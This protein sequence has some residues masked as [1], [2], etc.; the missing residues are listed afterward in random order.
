MALGIFAALA[1]GCSRSEPDTFRSVASGTPDTAAQDQGKPRQINMVYPSA[2]ALFPPE[3]AA[4]TFRWQDDNSTCDA[5]RIE[6]RFQDGPPLEFQSDSQEWT[7][8]DEDWEAIK[9]RSRSGDA[10]VTVVGVS[11]T[12]PDTFLSRGS[13]S[14]RTS[15]DEVGAPIFYREVNLPFR[16]AVKDPS[17]IRW[18][19]GEISARQ[20]PP[21]V[22]E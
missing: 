2:G 19:F 9:A 15:N 13:T 17:R 22:L 4:P 21:V 6:V 3:I 20:P 18:R 7:P 16:D 11:G 14:R 10:V 5:W 12:A 8:A 1:T